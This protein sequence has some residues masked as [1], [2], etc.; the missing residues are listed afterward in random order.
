MIFFVLILGKKSKEIAVE[1]L[2]CEYASRIASKG[3]GLLLR[4]MICS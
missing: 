1:S 4:E 3:T 2:G